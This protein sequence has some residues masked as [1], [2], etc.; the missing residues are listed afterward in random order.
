VL[1][2]D[3]GHFDVPNIVDVLEEAY[4]AVEHGVMTVDDFRDFTFTNPARFWTGGR[5]RTPTSSEAPAS[6]Q[7]SPRWAPPDRPPHRPTED[8]PCCSATPTASGA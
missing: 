1:S 3:I 5:A 8:H 7:Q 2:S 4:E 6:K